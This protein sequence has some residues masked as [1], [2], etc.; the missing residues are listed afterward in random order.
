MLDPTVEHASDGGQSP[1]SR[2]AERGPGLARS[3]A[4]E[5]LVNG[6]RSGAAPGGTKAGARGAEA[7]PKARARRAPH[8][9]G[10]NTDNC[11]PP[12]AVGN[13][14]GRYWLREEMAA[15]PR[16][17]ERVAECGWWT[18]AGQV[19][20]RDRAGAVYVAQVLVCGRPWAEPVC[21]AKIRTRKGAELS[22][23][24]DAHT[25]AGGGVS[26]ITLTAG[27]HHAD[28]PLAVSLA[29]LRT[30][31]RTLTGG[32]AHKRW[33]A[34]RAQAGVMG[35]TLAYEFTHG[36]AGWHPHLHALLW[37]RAP[38]DAEGIVGLEMYVRD[39]WAAVIGKTGRYLHPRHGMDFAWNANASA[40]GDYVTKVQEGDWGT[41]QEMTRGDIKA[42]RSTKGRTPFSILRDHYRWGDLA[43][44]GL[45]QEY[46]AGVKIAGERSIP[47][48]RSTPGLRAAI[49]G[50]GEVP[51][52]SDEQMALV[53]VGGELIAVLSW[54][55]WVRVRQ[56]RAVPDLL[57]AGERGGL[58]AMNELL[59]AWGLGWADPPPPERET[60]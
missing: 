23:M 43:D 20:I 56:A 11:G 42:A 26:M 60:R 58:A 38:L 19:E 52:L 49:L 12:Q 46:L 33:T 59:G 29:L 22:N 40:L 39:R 10:T 24:I 50:A 28:D 1:P 6:L 31:W 21:S 8:S 4:V 18:R 30:G 41:A 35:V 3:Q 48:L 37:H 15:D 54:R 51:A 5:P 34:L 2:R 27:E 36:A 14:A 57:A 47:L 16:T 13:R 55:V 32:G 17:Q 9:L 7:G 53:E 45:W 25:A 44:W